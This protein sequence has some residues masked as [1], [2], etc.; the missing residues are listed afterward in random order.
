MHYLSVVTCF[1]QRVGELM[2]RLLLRGGR[3]LSKLLLP[4]VD[5]VERLAWGDFVDIGGANFIKERMFLVSEERQ[6]PFV[7]SLGS[8]AIA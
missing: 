3:L 7:G 1:R 2:L 4:S 6:L 5:Q 8:M